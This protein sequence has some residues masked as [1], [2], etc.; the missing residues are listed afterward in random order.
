M[1]VKADLNKLIEQDSVKKELDEAAPRGS[2]AARIGVAGIANGEEASG[3]KGIKSPLKMQVIA[4]TDKSYTSGSVT[5]S[6]K[7]ATEFNLIDANGV[8]YKVNEIEW[9]V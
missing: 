3:D 6:I 8:I 7:Q 1:T 2:I 5:I 4:A 9:L